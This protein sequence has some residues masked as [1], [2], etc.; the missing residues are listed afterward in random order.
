M[1]DGERITKGGRARQKRREREREGDGDR[2]RKSCE[3]VKKK[4]I[5]EQREADRQ[6]YR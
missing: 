3:I 4:D 5:V 2:G 1:L 6:T